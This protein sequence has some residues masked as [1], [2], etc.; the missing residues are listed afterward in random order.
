[1]T[2]LQNFFKLTFFILH[3]FRKIIFILKT[4]K[5]SAEIEITINISWFK[6]WAAYVR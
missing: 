5:K 2:F 3:L 4:D 6:Y 1:M